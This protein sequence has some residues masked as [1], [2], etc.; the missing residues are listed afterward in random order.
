MK[1]IIHVNMHKIRSNRKNGTNEPVI[2]CKTYK[3][4]LYGHRVKIHGSS[5]VIY[6]P[7]KPLSCGA[8]LWIETYGKVR[9]IDDERKIVKE[10]P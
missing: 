5:Q 3:D 6:R 2:T 7:D 10:I 9:V 8:R 1:K 4:N